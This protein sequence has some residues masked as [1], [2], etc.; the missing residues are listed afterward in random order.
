MDQSLESLTVTPRFKKWIIAQPDMEIVQRLQSE[1]NIHPTLCRLLAIRGIN[2]FESAKLFFRPSLE[3][4]HDPFLMK[5]MDKAVERILQAVQHH[6]KIMIYGDYDVDGTTSV[7]LMYTFLRQITPQLIMYVPDR[8]KEGYG[9]SQL[10]IEHAAN[11]GCSLI[12]ALDCGIKAHDKVQFAKEKG[13]DFI[14]CDHHLPDQTLP[15]AIA[16]LD[17][18]RPDCLYPF[19]ELSGCGIGFK[20][21]QAIASK[22]G[23]DMQQVYD[24]LDFVV[25]STAA[26]IVPITGENRVLAYFGLEKVN[27]NPRPGLKALMVSAGVKDD[28]VLD[29]TDL[30][31]TVGPRINAAGRIKHGLHAVE[32]LI[33]TDI[34]AA[35]VKAGGVSDSNVTRQNLDKDITE[36][37]LEMIRSN[38]ALHGRRTTVLFQPHW[39]KGVIG[40]VASRLIEHFHRPTIILTA[41]NGMAVGSGRSVPGFDLHD[42]IHA[43]SHLLEQFGGHKYAA[44]LSMKIENIAAFTEA[45]EAIVDSRIEEEMLQP[46][47]DV[48]DVIELSDINEKFYNIVEQMGPFGPG[49]MRPVFV[50]R[51]V[52]DGGYTRLVGN[53]HLKLHVAKPG[54]GSRSGIGFGMWDYIPYIRSKQTFDICYQMYINEWNGNKNVEIRLK[55]LK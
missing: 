37:A 7:A 55:D 11:E 50:T 9:I 31:F 24:L 33:E 40:I 45:F 20:V 13:I 18:K 47:I 15:V 6:E 1:L 54:Q 4:L 25:V 48:D 44:G 42:A 16:V 53:D 41:S 5:D 26:D 23:M 35:H 17:P 19:K 29:I 8:Y 34:E 22:S 43:C 3:H 32:L 30:V 46:F 36:E 28:K 27:K 49:N 38:E 39:H 14:I 51:N 21:V 10:G 12:I 52:S 2:D